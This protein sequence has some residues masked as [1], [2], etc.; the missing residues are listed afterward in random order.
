MTLPTRDQLNA[1]VDRLFFIDHPDAP[2]RLDP[3]DPS[4][5][6]LV[7]AWIEI[8]DRIL[9]DWTDSVF[10]EFFPHAGRL[11]PNNSDDAQLIEYWKDIQHQI[12][13]GPPGQYSW[14]NPQP[15]Q[16]Y[17]VSI[18][19]HPSRNGAVVTFNRAVGVEE[20]EQFLWN[21]PPP[22]GA[23]IE[24]YGASGMF[25]ELS[26]NALQHTREDV[27]SRISEVMILTAD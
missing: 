23:T 25:L 2:Q 13:N 6:S 19:A 1:E 18:E 17:V 21:G 8:R 7:Q 16:L 9:A 26:I 3:D 4:Q 27:A 12:C 10:Y 15:E 11:D 20:A 22:V 14:D 5:A 24:Q